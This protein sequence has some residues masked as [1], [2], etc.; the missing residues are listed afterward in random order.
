MLKKEFPVP[1]EKWMTKIAILAIIAGTLLFA[2]VGWKIIGGVVIS[3][4]ILILFL[5]YHM[6]AAPCLEEVNKDIYRV[7]IKEPG[8][9]PANGTEEMHPDWLAESKIQN[10]TH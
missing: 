3:Y 1:L 9:D 10:V 6:G 8:M 2:V 7:R 4:G 5:A